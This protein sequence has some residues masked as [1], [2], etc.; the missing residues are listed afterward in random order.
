MHLTGVPLQTLIQLGALAGAAVVVFYIL[1]LRRRPVAVPFSK[2]WQKIL[3]DK[4]ATSLFSQ[5]KRLLS[6]LLQLALSSD[7]HRDARDAH[8]IAMGVADRKRAAAN[9]DDR[10]IWPPD[11]V[12]LV[13]GPLALQRQARH[14]ALTGLI[15]RREFERRLDAALLR[16]RAQ[17]MPYSLLYLDLDHFKVVNDTCGHAA[18]D[19]LLR[20]ITGILRAT[21]R[22]RDSVARLGGDEFAVLLEN[23][24]PQPAERIAQ[25]LLQ[26]IQA[27]SFTWT[28]KMFKIGASIGLVSFHDSSVDLLE[29]MRAA[30]DACYVAKKEGR[31]RIHVYKATDGQLA[32]RQGELDWVG[33]LRHALDEGQFCLYAQEV[34]GVSGAR[35]GER[36]QELLLRMIDSE[37]QVIDPIVFIPVAERYN[38]MPAVDR[39]VISTAF[40]EFARMVGKESPQEKHRWAI[41]LSGASLSQDD[42]LGFV[43]KQFDLYAIPHSAICFEITETAAIANLAKATHLIHEL[44]ALGCGFSLDDFGSGMSSFAYLKHLP[45]DHLKIDGAFVRDIAHDP[46]DRAMVEAINKVGHVMGLTT[47]AE[48][49]ETPETLAILEVIGVDYAQ[50]FSIARPHLYITPRA[51]AVPKFDQPTGVAASVLNGAK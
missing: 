15:T 2:I 4:E 41:N 37:Q 6:L 51:L 14:D 16:A 33:R 25:Q 9:P 13:V 50:G 30:D 3:R 19:E 42:F 27:F 36:H 46:I 5:L 40:A 43:R 26:T 23:C 20:Q 28:D 10:A 21:I 8:D 48:C 44:K 35:K 22:D 29:L 38:L 24:P 45:V 17:P 47:I 49:V 18:G 11:P 39:L 32:A 7:I 1:K 34:I 12:G 31:N